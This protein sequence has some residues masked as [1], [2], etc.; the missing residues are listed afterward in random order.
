MKAYR[1]VWL[2][3]CAALGV[4]GVSVA[5]HAAPDHFV[6]LSVECGVASG[7]WS[8]LVARHGARSR[9]SWARFVCLT[10]LAG[11]VAGGAFV[12]FAVVFGP[13]VV[14]LVLALAGTSPAALRLAAR[15]VRAALAPSEGYFEI[16][17][18]ALA[19]SGL[20]FVPVQR[21]DDLGLLTDE[22]LCD[23]WRTST[24][25]LRQCTPQRLKRIAAQRQRYLD[26]FERRNPKGL[27]VWLTSSDT[28]ACDPRVFLV[29]GWADLPAVDW[30]ELTGGQGA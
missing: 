9:R 25:A 8:L 27:K 19:Y 13:G 29:E 10:S 30:D 16:A 14:A 5:F 4:V 26:E 7:I 22:Q 24:A 28:A 1:V 21:G 17:G 20:G 23:A 3:V 2:I 15:A 11:G 18:N 6:V 12:G